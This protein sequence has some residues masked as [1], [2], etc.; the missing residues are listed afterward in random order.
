MEN[1]KSIKLIEGEF[2]V[3]DARDIL[4]SLIQSKIQ[5]HEN[6]EFSSQIRFGL[7]DSNS[8][9]RIN[10]L[11]K[12]INELKKLFDECDDKNHKLIINTTIQIEIK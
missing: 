1:K 5:Y 9:L 10:N 7:K 3:S 12:D 2:N 8:V 6:K 4:L 11:K